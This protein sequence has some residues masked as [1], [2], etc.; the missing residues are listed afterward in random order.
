MNL[1]VKNRI[2]AGLMAISW[3]IAIHIKKSRN[4]EPRYSFSQKN[5]W[6][7][8]KNFINLFFN[9]FCNQLSLNAHLPQHPIWRNVD[10]TKIQAILA[11]GAAFGHGLF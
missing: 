7:V 8:P 10:A 5:G 9:M 3:R 4:L 2:F 11:V 1:V 6:V